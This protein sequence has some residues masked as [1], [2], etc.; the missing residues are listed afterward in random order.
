MT[1]FSDHREFIEEKVYPAS[2]DPQKV[3]SVTQY[4]GINERIGV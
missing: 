3:I 4:A 2:F 1:L